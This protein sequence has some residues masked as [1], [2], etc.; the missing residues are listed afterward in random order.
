MGVALYIG[1]NI[2]RPEMLFWSETSGNFVYK[3][4]YLFIVLAALLK[5]YFSRMRE[6][7]NK[8]VVLMILMLAGVLL[9][10]A[11]SIYSGDVNSQYAIELAKNI[12]FCLLVVLIVNTN[13]EIVLMQQIMLG[14]FSILGFWGIIQ[15]IHGNERVEGLGGAAWPDSNFVAAIFVLFLPL[16]IAQLITAARNYHRLAALGVLLTMLVLI[17]CTKSRAGAIGAIISIVMF[18]FFAKKMRNTLISV[19]TGVV[20]IASFA[21]ESYIERMNTMRSM[22]HA[23]FSALSRIT[24]WQ[25]AA[26]VFVDNPLL[27]TGF[28]TYPEAKMKYMN[29]F[30]E[31]DESF[32]KEVFRPENKKVTHNTY[33]QMLSDCGLV[34]GGAFIALI[35]SAIMMGFSSRQLLDR[36]PEIASSVYW[37]HAICAGICGFAACI[38]TLDMVTIIFIY[39]QITFAQLLKSNLE[40]RCIAPVDQKLWSA[41]T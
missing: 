20:L 15:S 22:D 29:R 10:E 30:Q 25:A 12:G 4:L 9:S 34:G 18:G 19:T 40:S 39:L 28:M 2:I 8:Q 38:F 7:A 14:C 11:F 24:L 3:S 37:L 6:L 31:L 26:M 13:D 27:G 33:L 17:V 5:G 16:A 32:V 36:H 41:G 35:V 1:L 21:G 23:D